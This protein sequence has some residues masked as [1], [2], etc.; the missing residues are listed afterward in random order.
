MSQIR[1]LRSY[2]QR[3]CNEKGSASLVDIMARFDFH[4]HAIPTLN[5]MRQ[6]I[7]GIKAIEMKREGE[8]VFLSIGNADTEVGVKEIT[9][10]DMKNTYDSYIKKIKQRNT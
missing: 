2:I 10:I 7:K 6:A 9:E 1:N 5:E 4:Q 3:E 8:M